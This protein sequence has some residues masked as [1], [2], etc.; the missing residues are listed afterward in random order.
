M[1]KKELIKFLDE[2]FKPLEFKRKGNA[3]KN[4]NEVFVKV[5]NIQKSKYSNAY[6]LN[7]G[8]IIKGL[9]L[10]NLEMHVY[11]RLSSINDAENQKIMDLLDMENNIA[12]NKRKSDLMMFIDKYLL[13]KIQ[14][15]NTQNDL[16]NAL[17]KRPHLNDI[18]LVVK[19]HL[20]LD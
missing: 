17:K 7:F 8:F 1:E 10:N 5:I 11:N 13:A 3:W 4:E 15:T 2:I 12:D 6:Y 18:P 14:S 16:V 20:K 19:R 9:D